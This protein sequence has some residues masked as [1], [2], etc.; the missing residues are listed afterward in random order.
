[1]ATSI[2]LIELHKHTRRFRKAQRGN[3]LITFALALIPILGA[4]GAAVDYSRANNIRSQLIAAADAASVGAVAKSS[5]AV[6]AALTM[7]ND[8]AIPAGVTDALKIFNAQLTGKSSYYNSLSA[9][10]TVTKANGSVTSVVQFTANVPTVILGIFSKGSIAIS[11]T[12]K[13][14]TSMPQYID[15]YLLLDN[16]PSMGVGA[17]TA[18]INTMVANTPDQCAF[19]CHDL[20]TSPNDYYSKAKSLGVTMRIDV[21]R[22]ATQQLMDTAK[23]IENYTNQFRMAIYTFGTGCNN[24]GL[25]T[26]QSLTSN[27]TTAKTAAAAIDLMTVPYQNYNSDQ[28]TNFDDTLGDL[29]GVIASPGSG[30]TSSSPQKYVFFVSDGV[31][32]ANNP[33]SC[34]KP[35]SGSTR[36]QEPLDIAAC[37][38]IKNRGIKI[39]VLYTTYLPLPTNAWYKS[40]IGP[41][42][43]QIA[44]NMQNCASPELFFEVSPSQGVSEAMNALFKKAVAQ[45]HLTQ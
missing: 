28:C 33:T 10:A 45:A 43:S 6:A 23:G 30:T 3:V 37:T 21:L 32:D 26:I 13:A 19:A 4:V 9:S 17:T 14:A 31:A 42:Q 12:S 40:W 11:G 27:L 34:S 18:D 38:A 44:T 29:N 24:L 20:S 8:G 39:A 25:T 7:A 5:P 36:C 1:M 22:T 15:F 41:W 35:L 2:T 16:T